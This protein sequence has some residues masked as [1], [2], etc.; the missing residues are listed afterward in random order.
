MT[1]SEDKEIEEIQRKIK[2][3]GIIE[4]PGSMM[5]GLGLYAKFG[6]NGDPF[7]PILK[8]ETLVILLLAVGTAIMTWGACRIFILS[9]QKSKLACKAK[10]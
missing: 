3:T 8:N 9:R 2:I 10:K 5:L 4:T 1:L 6:A 7:H